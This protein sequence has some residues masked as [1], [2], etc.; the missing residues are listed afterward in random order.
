MHEANTALSVFSRDPP[1][2]LFERVFFVGFEKDGLLAELQAR[3][4]RSFL[5]HT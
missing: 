3:T 2:R 4:S 5:P 1:T